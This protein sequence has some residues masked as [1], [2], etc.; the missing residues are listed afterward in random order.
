MWLDV[1][2]LRLIHPS[3]SWLA[4]ESWLKVYRPPQKTPKLQTEALQ[5]S[6]ALLR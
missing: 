3:S 2:I 1:T 5:S 4:G 6:R